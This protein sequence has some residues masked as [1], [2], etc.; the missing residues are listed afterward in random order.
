VRGDAEE[1]RKFVAAVNARLM[2]GYV[3]HGAPFAAAGDMLFQA[4]ALPPP[5]APPQVVYLPAPTQHYDERRMAYGTC[6]AEEQ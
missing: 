6:G 1:L 4:L 3:L 2:E 5:T